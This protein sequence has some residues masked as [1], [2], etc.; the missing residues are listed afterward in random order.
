MP[1]C[2]KIKYAHGIIDHFHTWSQKRGKLN[3]MD[4]LNVDIFKVLITYQEFLGHSCVCVMLFIFYFQAQVF[5]IVRCTCS[6]WK[7]DY[8]YH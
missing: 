2:N 8:Y 6:V 1:P 5:K 7:L 4:S 3:F